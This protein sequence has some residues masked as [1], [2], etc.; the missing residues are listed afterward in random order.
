MLRLTLLVWSLW[1]LLRRLLLAHLAVINDGSPTPATAFPIADVMLAQAFYG[2]LGAG[3]TAYFRFTAAPGT[4]LRL[5]LLVPQRSYQ[6]GF[7]PTVTLAGPGLSAAEWVMPARDE[8]MRAGTT[9]YQ[10]TQRA[11]LSLAGGSYLVAI[12]ADT[13]GVY[14]FCTGIREPDVYADAATRARVQ[15]LLED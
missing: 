14:C 4:P 2:R 15:A 9:L 7:H 13:A 3:E 5:S 12:Q 1:V 10:R 8:G 11:E 6:A